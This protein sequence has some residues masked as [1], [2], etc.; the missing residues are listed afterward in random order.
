MSQIDVR[1]VFRYRLVRI[2]VSVI[3]GVQCFAIAF[4][5]Q[6]RCINKAKGI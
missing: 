3:E 5:N 4:V 6:K 2:T 1:H